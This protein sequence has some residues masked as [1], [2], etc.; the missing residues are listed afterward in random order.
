LKIRGKVSKINAELGYGFV[1]C[2]KDGEVFFS[3]ETTFSGASFDNLRVNDQVQIE[4]VNTER[5]LFAQRL[6]K[7]LPKHRAPEL[8]V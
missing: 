2:P 4:I 7:E 3:T 5:G 8:T 6:E 1:I